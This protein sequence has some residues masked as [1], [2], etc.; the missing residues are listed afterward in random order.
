VEE[1]NEIAEGQIQDSP[2][3]GLNLKSRP[4]ELERK[5]SALDDVVLSTEIRGL[6]N[7]GYFSNSYNPIW[8][9]LF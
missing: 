2:S 6:I 5:L 4:P 8:L 7:E 3:S 9:W 1:L